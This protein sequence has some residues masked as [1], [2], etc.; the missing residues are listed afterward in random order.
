MTL[1]CVIISLAAIC[2]ISTGLPLP[3]L[4]YQTQTNPSPQYWELRPVSTAQSVNAEAALFNSYIQG[5][6]DP[7]RP[8]I[9]MVVPNTDSDAYEEQKL[10]PGNPFI[11]PT[12]PPPEKTTEVPPTGILCLVN[13]TNVTALNLNGTNI[14]A[15]LLKETNV[16]TLNISGINVT[17]I[18]LNGTNVTAL[19]LTVCRTNGN[20]T[21]TV[22]PAQALL[23]LADGTTLYSVENTINKESESL[24]NG[25]YEL[26]Y[27]AHQPINS[28]FPQSPYPY[29]QYTDY[30]P[31][32]RIPFSN[33]YYTGGAFQQVYVYKPVYPSS[34][35]SYDVF[36]YLPVENEKNSERQSQ[37]MAEKSDQVDSKKQDK[38][39]K[40]E[41]ESNADNQKASELTMP[42][43]VEETIDVQEQALM[44]ALIAQI[45]G[46]KQDDR[47]LPDEKIVE[48]VM[49]EDN[50]TKEK[51]IEEAENL[52]EELENISDEDLL[53][54]VEKVLQ[55]LH[56][57]LTD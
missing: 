20:E 51:E 39:P 55:Q 3:R 10:I 32:N 15:L 19:N 41:S 40:L 13:G 53:S 17:A 1:L 56:S 50:D 37:S 23:M 11:G 36:Y 14:T 46:D 27:V 38:V 47:P 7:D 2:S 16:T 25:A 24:L 18:N 30:D 31:F 12:P 6:F 9:Q 54:A 5:M 26:A 34:S 21:H 4:V 8:Y 57:R 35:R 44:N 43:A 45:Q 52:E 49:I 42:N 48:E 29:V 33:P 22:V 28:F